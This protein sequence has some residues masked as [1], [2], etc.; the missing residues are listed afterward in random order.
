MKKLLPIKPFRVFKK[1]NN[2]RDDVITWL[3]D[4]VVN[5]Y[6]HK[7]KQLYLHGESNTGKNSFI[8]HLM[9]KFF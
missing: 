9:G 7:K 8:N 5:G 3:E 1:F 2:W 6:S 4:W